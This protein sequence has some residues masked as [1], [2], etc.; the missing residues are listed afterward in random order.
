MIT[1]RNSLRQIIAL[2]LAPA[3]IRVAPLM[4]I[5]PSLVAPAYDRTFGVEVEPGVFVHPCLEPLVDEYNSLI[6][7]RNSNPFPVPFH[8]RQTL[9]PFE[10]R[11]LSKA[12][13]P[14]TKV[15]RTS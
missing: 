5:K 4:Q 13:R 8:Y 9:Q 3:I 11:M 1:R 6:V 7:V 10:L 2:G 12:M 14:P 15:W